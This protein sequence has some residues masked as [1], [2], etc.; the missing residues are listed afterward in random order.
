METLI[1][2]VNAAASTDELR[3]IVN[4]ACHADLTCDQLRQLGGL[5]AI[6][7]FVLASQ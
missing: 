3:K 1:Q 5:I 7:T 6:R 4:D 2:R